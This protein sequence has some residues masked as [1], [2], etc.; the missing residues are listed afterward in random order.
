MFSISPIWILAGFGGV[1]DLGERFRAPIN[2]DI[3]ALILSS[4]FDPR[5]P[6]R[7]G[8]EVAAGFLNSVHLVADDLGHWICH[9]TPCIA[10]YAKFLHQG[11]LPDD[12]KPLRLAQ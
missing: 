2:S 11:L 12:V 10:I 8:D 7:N 1:A 6:V 5:T 4:E 9:E 3:P